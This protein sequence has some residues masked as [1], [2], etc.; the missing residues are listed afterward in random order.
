MPVKW[1][2]ARMGVAP[3]RLDDWRRRLGKPNA[4]AGNLPKG[5]W[6]SDAER[7][8]VVSFYLEHP[9]DG[10]RR[11]AYMMIDADVA[12]VSPAS[13]YR[14]LKNAGAIKASEARPSLKGTGFDQPGRPHEHWHTDITYVKIG[15]RFYY[16]VCVLDGYSRFILHWGL[17]ASMEEWEAAVVQ[18]G[19]L[20]KFPRP[21]C[22][23]IT[24]NGAQFVGREFRRFIAYHGLTH[25]RTSPHYPQSNGKIERFHGSLKAE[26][27][28]HKAL[29]G[30]EHAEEVIRSYV[31]AYNRRRLHSAVGYVTPLDKLEGR[32]ADVLA[33]RAAKMK[34]AAAS[35]AEAAKSSR[36]PL[37]G[38][39]GRVYTMELGEA[40]EG[41]A[42]ERPPKE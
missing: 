32:D 13:V 7:E 10:Y 1:F 9:D 20:D 16:L 3:A 26:C 27:L 8:A 33:A 39:G 4:A 18:Q 41:N 5:R 34:A 15:G 40:E 14:V 21:G 42:G 12:Y 24:D 38:S 23:Y 22:R 35:R 6:L 29:T 31:D 11:C 37:A 28:N 36:R 17:R 30:P 2:C 19:A 25:V